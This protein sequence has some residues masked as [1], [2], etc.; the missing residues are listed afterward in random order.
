MSDIFVWVGVELLKYH[1][2]RLIVDAWKMSFLLVSTPDLYFGCL[3]SRIFIGFLLVL[4]NF[5][6]VSTR[7]LDRIASVKFTPL[8]K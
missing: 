1:S 6:R 8:F 2:F 5:E 7:I 4:L 3:C